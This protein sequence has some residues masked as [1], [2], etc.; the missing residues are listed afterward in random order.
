CS[1]DLAHQDGDFGTYVYKTTDLG[2]TWKRLSV[3]IP[4]SNSNFANQIRED[5]EKK[6]LLWLGTD[7]A[8]YF[9][10]DD[11]ESWIRFKHG[12]PPAPVYGIAIQKQFNDLVIGT[13]GRGIYILDD[14]TPI[15]EFSEAVQNSKVHLFTPGI[16]YRFQKVD[17]IKSKSAFSD[18]KNPTYGVSI[19]YFLKESPSDSVH[20]IVRNV[21]GRDVQH[22]VTRGEKGINRTWWNLRHDDY[23]F[24]PLRT[25]PKG[26]DWVKLDEHGT[27][28]M[29]I[30]DLDIGPGMRPTLVP[31]GQ[32]TVILKVG[33]AELKQSVQVLKDPNTK[34]SLDDIQRQYE[35]GM[36]IYTGVSTCLSLI[37]EME[38]VRSRLLEKMK[39]PKSARWAA[40]LEQKIYDLEARIFDVHQTGARQDIFRN[41]AKILER[42]LAI[43]KEGQTASADFPPTDQQQEVYSLL[44]KRMD[45]VVSEFESLKRSLEWKKNNLD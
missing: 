2:K 14:V 9:S 16:A 41:P 28:K 33:D 6:G 18:G 21:Q 17:G 26:K 20:L 4:P 12:L 10:P 42:F 27:R 37:D 15:R 5:P 30:Y 38:Q 39:D 25:K 34:S 22:I 19:N 32:Y 1:S 3:N 40:P 13:Y 8:L 45:D 11:G 29:F 24:P 31:P 23:N 44:K 7:N 43:A 36:K 35:F